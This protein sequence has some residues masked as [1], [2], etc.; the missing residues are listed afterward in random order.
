MFNIQLTTVKTHLCKCILSIYFHVKSGV[1]VWKY[2][3]NIDNFLK[4]AVLS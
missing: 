3:T 4:V 1:G 2:T